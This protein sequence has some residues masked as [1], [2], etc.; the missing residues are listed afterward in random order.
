[1]AAP[2]LTSSLPLPLHSDGLRIGLLGG[3]FNPP[4]HG[5]RELSLFAMKRLQLDQVWW[6][7]TPGNPLK[8]ASA[9]QGQSVRAAA[10]R[11]VARHPKIQVSCL[12]G[13]IGTRYTV[14]TIGYLRRHCRNVR[15][16]WIMGADN[17]AQFHRWQGFRRIAAQVPIAVID[18]PPLSLRALAAPAAQL[19]A[20]YR[21]PEAAAAS[22]AAR[23][24][25][26]WVYLTGMKSPVA[27]TRLRN[28]DGSWKK[29]D[30]PE[31]HI[32]RLTP[33]A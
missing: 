21:L 4:H 3:S 6:L 15:F 16:V 25:P 23:R 2:L 28:P 29:P 19:L 31:W 18:R 10:A 17:L 13:V 8:D 26:A 12:E 5:H 30:V 9:L 32:E 14:D 11:A 24:P 22:L 33:H 20:R 1:M 27:S 7:V